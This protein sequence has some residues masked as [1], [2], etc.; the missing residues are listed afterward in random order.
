MVSYRTLFWLKIKTISVKCQ[1]ENIMEAES[2]VVYCGYVTNNVYP[3]TV[4]N[5]HP[6]HLCHQRIVL[7]HNGKLKSMKLEPVHI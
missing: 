1:D 6:S 4:R 2:R 7:L 3:E 5:K